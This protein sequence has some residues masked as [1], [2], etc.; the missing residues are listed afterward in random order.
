METQTPSPPPYVPPVGCP[1]TSVRIPDNQ[2]FRLKSTIYPNTWL[3]A[4]FG[5]STPAAGD[6][7]T[8]NAIGDAVRFTAM[9]GE[10]GQISMIS[11][12]TR[13]NGP[14]GRIDSAFYRYI[15]D[16]QG[17]L[18][19]DQ[20]TTTTRPPVQFCLQPDNTFVMHTNGTDGPGANDPY[21]V[22]VCSST[23]RFVF[24]DNGSGLSSLSGCVQD[25]MIYDPIV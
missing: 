1:S 13:F 6:I 20:S 18:Y 12:G 7:R 24:L 2:L 4:T 14:V 5:G 19:F 22:V 10:T 8:T 3:S 15:N 25:T 21:M 9:P 17:Y 11:T 23:S 16:N